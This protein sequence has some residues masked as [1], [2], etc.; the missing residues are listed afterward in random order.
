MKLIKKQDKTQTVEEEIV[1][2]ADQS[3]GN[4]IDR[5]IVMLLSGLATGGSPNC[6][7]LRSIAGCEG[8]AFARSE[9]GKEYIKTLE[10]KEAEQEKISKKE[11]HQ[12]H[13]WESLRDDLKEAGL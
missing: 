6:S 4:G 10:R 2:T 9:K 3:T 5:R 1:D 12:E 11:T 13:I 7:R 8:I